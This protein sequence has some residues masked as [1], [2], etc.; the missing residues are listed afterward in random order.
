MS[1]HMPTICILDSFQTTKKEPVTITSRDTRPRNIK[2]LK[3]HLNTYDWPKLLGKPILDAN[4]ETLSNVLKLETDYCTPIKTRKIRRNKLRR[5]PW[6]TAQLKQCID[7][8]KRLYRS[9]LRKSTSPVDIS[10][11]GNYKR[12]LRCAIRT[13]KR[14]YHN[15]KC[16]EF[17]NKKLWQVI[18]EIVGKNRDKSSTI[19]YLTISGI[20]EYGA[21]KVSNSLAKYFS[22]VGHQYANNIPRSK[23]VSRNIFTTTT[24][25]P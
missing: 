18:N 2:A 13:A 16:E 14:L 1:D 15:N 9:S 6:M 4:V 12:T 8:S 20:K 23:A 3:E 19:D 21:K 10:T 7:K 11:Y 24:K 5:E 17:Q 22:R 25:K